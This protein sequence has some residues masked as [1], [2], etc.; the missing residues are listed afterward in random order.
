MFIGSSAPLSTHN[1][2]SEVFDI[3]D[4]D[5]QAVPLIEIDAGIDAAE[6]EDSSYIKEES[7]Q[8]EEEIQNE[9]QAKKLAA[10]ERRREKNRLSAQK[11]REV[12]A[13]KLNFYDDMKE[14]QYT[15]SL[16]ACAY[17]SPEDKKTITTALKLKKTEKFPDKELV[18]TYAKVNAKVLEVLKA[19]Q[20][21]LALLRAQLQ[22][23]DTD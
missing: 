21:E 22:T 20:A 3:G 6:P 17:F 15:F 11:S 1:F 10:I 5:L 12:K 16:E 9:I 18:A 4:E 2:L 7:Q 19:Q 8:D 13:L 23:A 14:E